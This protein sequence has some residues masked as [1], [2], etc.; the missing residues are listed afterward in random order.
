[1]KGVILAG[2][3][4]S[5][6]HPLTLL[7]SK[8]LLPVFDKPLIFYPL[9]TLMELGIRRILI[10]S[11]PEFQPMF[12]KL[13]GS[14]S[15][16]GIEISY[17]IQLRA[18]GLAQGLSLAEAFINS[19]NFFFIL[20]D[21]LFYGNDYLNVSFNDTGATIFTKRVKDPENYGVVEYSSEN[22]VLNLIEKPTSYVSSE[23]VVGLYQYD[24]S[25]F[26]R[27]KN[28]SKSPRGE[29]EITDLNKSYLQD[30]Q[31]N[32]IR[33]SNGTTWFDTGGFEQ[34]HDAS[35]FVRG[36]QERTGIRIGD[37]ASI[38]QVKGWI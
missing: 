24:A 26:N 31:L 5:R 34:L 10:I 28:I 30:G 38:A 23:A 27:V 7:T 37:P 13:L 20:G 11:T 4:G 22:K 25:A 17:E 12:K 9:S 2:G 15:Q 35:G 6:L 19:E 33:L 36:I 18:D 21:N 8:Q 3:K 32:I 14:G 29:F 16:F 1:M